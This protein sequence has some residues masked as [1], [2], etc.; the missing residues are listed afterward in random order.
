M[1]RIC[2]KVQ[3]LAAFNYCFFLK[4]IIMKKTLTNICRSI[5]EHISNIFRNSPNGRPAII[6]DK[7]GFKL[8]FGFFQCEWSREWKYSL[9]GEN[10]TS[11]GDAGSKPALHSF[12]SYLSCIEPFQSTSLILIS[13]FKTRSTCLSSI[14]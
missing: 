6:K 13:P 8:N 14:S 4:Y 1:V 5:S 2:V 11:S 9:S 3:I 12:Y 7:L 10:N